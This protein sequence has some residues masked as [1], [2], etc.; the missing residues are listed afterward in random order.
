MKSLLEG[1]GSPYEQSLAGRLQ[2]IYIDPPFFS[3]SAYG[4]TTKAGSSRTDVKQVAYL[5][6]WTEGLYEY[7]K[8]LCIRFYAMRD[9]LSD[10]G[11][12]WVHLDWHV[13]HYVK[14]LMDEVFGAENF[15]NEVV[16]TYK[17]GGSTKR[18]FARKHDTLLV[19]SKG[20]DYYFKPQV[21]KSYNRGLKPYR[22]KGVE[23]FQDE[24]GW[25]TMVNMKDV[26]QIDMVG[27]TSGERTGYATQKPEALLERIIDSCTREGDLV[28]DF[29]GGSGTL[30]AV[31]ARKGRPFI[32]CDGGR[33]ALA[34]A[35]K[36]LLQQGAS[37]DIYQQEGYGKGSFANASCSI[38][39]DKKT[40]KTR[41]FLDKYWVEDL[42]LLPIDKKSLENVE[43]LL[44]IDALGL[45][46]F[47]M[48]DYNYSG[49][50]LNPSTVIMSNK[51]VLVN[52]I[53]IKTESVKNV[54]VRVTDIFGDTILIMP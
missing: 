33:L 28:A 39:A 24:I 2:L 20:P 36:R 27:R 43:K 51:G 6:T 30:A 46:D 44:Q 18:H 23:E 53:E 5:D 3:K 19:Y 13:V 22:F 25:Y 49:M 35:E 52:E 12:V 31:A 8:M 34:C 15:V 26:W 7:L 42:N 50:V 10:T 16:W 14:I 45:V 48:V 37:F 41:I 21:E 47:W 1:A 38:K 40:G 32:Y 29:F 11:L 54:A 9:L 17:S 4:V